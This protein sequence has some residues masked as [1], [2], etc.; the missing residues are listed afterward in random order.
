ME[1]LTKKIIIV[2]VILVVFIILV[3][4]MGLDVSQYF[5]ISPPEITSPDAGGGIGAGSGGI[6]Q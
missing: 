6:I 5:A 2:I 1:K 4:L 3:N